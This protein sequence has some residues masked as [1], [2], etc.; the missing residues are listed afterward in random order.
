MRC[1]A[2]WS[3]FCLYETL[4]VCF[5]ARLLA[6]SCSEAVTGTS[7]SAL[8]CYHWEVKPSPPRHIDSLFN[9]P[10]A[11]NPN[12]KAGGTRAQR[13]QGRLWHNTVMKAINAGLGGGKPVSSRLD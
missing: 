10:A 6:C 9:P 1:A 5:C 13:K 3:F 8:F 2:T 11:T 12:D 7:L 4:G